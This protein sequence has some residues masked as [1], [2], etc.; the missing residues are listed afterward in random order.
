MPKGAGAYVR[1]GLGAFPDRA[2]AI[3]LTIKTKRTRRAIKKNREASAPDATERLETVTLDRFRG[4]DEHIDYR[5]R[6]AT[7]A[8]FQ[9]AA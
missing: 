5:C 8:G 1:L 2:E 9:S 6:I 7:G 3:P 4:E